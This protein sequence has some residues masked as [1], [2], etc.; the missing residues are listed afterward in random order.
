MRC[1]DL[2]ITA[3]PCDLDEIQREQDRV[4][5]PVR[6]LVVGAREIG[7]FMG[8]VLVVQHELQ[9]RAP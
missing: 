1:A 6:G 9:Y 3:G 2:P 8:F 7:E 5:L 4:R